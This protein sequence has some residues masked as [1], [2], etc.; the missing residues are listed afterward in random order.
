VDF[1]HKHIFPG[2]FLLRLTALTA[3]MTLA[4]N[5]CTVQLEDIGP[6]YAEA[7]AHW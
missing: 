7:L 4:S 6:H 2:D 3:S 1:I 5:L